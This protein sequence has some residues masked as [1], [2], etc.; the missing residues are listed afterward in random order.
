MPPEQNSHVTALI[1]EVQRLDK[2]GLTMPRSEFERRLAAALKLDQDKPNPIKK[3]KRPPQP[4]A[5]DEEFKAP[6]KKTE[7]DS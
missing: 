2:E 3:R 1:K 4:L 6:T 5:G 7:S